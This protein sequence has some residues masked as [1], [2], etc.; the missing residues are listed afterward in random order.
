[1]QSPTVC[2][3][4]FSSQSFLQAQSL[5]GY[6]AFVTTNYTWLLSY[7]IVAVGTRKNERPYDCARCPCTEMSTSMRARVKT[8]FFI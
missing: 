7:T 2:C 8:F 6:L 4:Y 1:M 5:L 3:K